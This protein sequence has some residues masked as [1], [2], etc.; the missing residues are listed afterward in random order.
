MILP[1]WAVAEKPTRKP[2]PTR[3]NKPDR[4]LSLSG[5]HYGIPHDLGGL[6]DAFLVC[7]GIY[8][9]RYCFV[10][11]P[12]GLRYTGNISAVGDGNTGEGVPQLMWMQIWDT[13]P[14]RKLFQIAG[15]GLRVH[16]LGAGLFREYIGAEAFLRLYN[17][18]L[19]K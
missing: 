6:A 11:V 3:K 2:T 12:E 14:L 9:Q 15:G 5:F 16:W 4:E 17:A 1:K 7:V 18:K 8:S 19:A 13:V 10:A